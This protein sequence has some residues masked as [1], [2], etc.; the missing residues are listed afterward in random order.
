MT[1]VK[2]ERRRHHQQPV[3]PGEAVER[4][5]ERAAHRRARAV[6]ADQIAAGVRLASPVAPD[7]DLDAGVVLAE[8]RDLAA[9]PQ[10][11]M[12]VPAHL[13]VQDARQ[14]RLLALQ[15]VGVGG[16]VGDAGEVELGQQPVLLGAVLEAG[17][18]SPC[19]IIGSAAPSVS[20]MSSVGGWKVEARDSS[21][22]VRAGL[23]HGHRHAVIAPIGRGDQP[24]RAAPAS[25]RASSQAGRATRRSAGMRR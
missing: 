15:A 25:R 6:G 21:L 13:L 18:I 12:A 9:E 10:I 11:E 16:D 23:E 3:R 5:A 19:A 7:R 4:D 8:V 22:R 24:D 17:A 1:L 20:S 14:L 2:V